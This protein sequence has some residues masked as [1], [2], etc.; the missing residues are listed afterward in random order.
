MAHLHF[1]PTGGAAGDMILA[2]LISAGSSLEEVSSALERL[3]VDFELS[4]QSVEVSGISSLRVHVGCPEEHSHRTLADIRGL[5]SG[6]GLPDRVVERSLAAFHRLAEAEGAVHG[7][8][9]E[10]VTFHEVGAVDS[11]VDTVGSCMAL[12]LLDVDTVSCGPLPLG[13][14]TVVAA[15]GPLPVPAPATLEALRDCRVRWTEEPRETT[16]PTGAALMQSLT[17]GEFTE[18][19]PPM[20]VRGIGY[21]AGNASLLY[22]PNLLRAALGEM[23]GPSGELELLEANVDDAS[24]ELLGSA[25]DR[26][27]EAGA[28]DAWLEHIVMKRGR[29]AYKLCA[30]VRGDEREQMARLMMRETGTLGVRHRSIGR[31]VADR[32]VVTVELPYGEC[33]VKVGELD[34]EAFSVAPEHA[35]AEK[36]ARER[37]LSLPRVYEDA[38]AAFFQSVGSQP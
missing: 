11:I 10:E 33:R 30:L 6:S 27:L 8:P 12:E 15:H 7:I 24:G 14:G 23:E 19:P 22:A 21:G 35:D 16:T 34:G 25:V 26:L 36:L 20:T 28:P 32:R 9:P 1:Q 13:H 18:S 29:G 2:S 37:D 3:G 31:T 38:K 4:S 5:V 17:G